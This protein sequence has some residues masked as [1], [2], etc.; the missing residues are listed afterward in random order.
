MKKKHIFLH[1]MANFK[2]N[3][4]SIFRLSV[5]ETGGDQRKPDR[6]HQ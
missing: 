4:S 2:I 3:C 5:A 1:R 6:K